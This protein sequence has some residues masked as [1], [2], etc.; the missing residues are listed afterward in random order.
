MKVEDGHVRMSRFEL[1]RAVLLFPIGLFLAV[2]ITF[3]VRGAWVPS[4]I[5]LLAA[6]A[7]FAA[8]WRWNRRREADEAIARAAQYEADG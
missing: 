6:I 4:A 1:Q 7:Y 2:P 8:M 3:A 5:C